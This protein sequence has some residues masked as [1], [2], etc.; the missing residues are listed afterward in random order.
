LYLAR[1]YN[2]LVPTNGKSIKNRQHGFDFTG[3]LLYTK[4]LI[5]AVILFANTFPLSLISAKLLLQ[6]LLFLGGWI[7]TALALDNHAPYQTGQIWRKRHMNAI[8]RGKK[9]GLWLCAKRL[10]TV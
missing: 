10:K 7:W 6:I 1:I 9:F 2:I 8:Q 3:I 4:C 5:F